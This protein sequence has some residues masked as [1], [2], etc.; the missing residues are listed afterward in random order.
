MISKDWVFNDWGFFV[1]MYQSTHI[2]RQ[3][4]Q[5]FSQGLQTQQFISPF[6][7]RGLIHSPEE[8]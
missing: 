8:E 6:E 1:Y 5:V 4:F 7:S 2:D 3:E